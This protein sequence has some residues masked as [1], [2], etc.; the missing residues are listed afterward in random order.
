MILYGHLRHWQALDLCEER[1]KGEIDSLE[2]TSERRNARIVIG[3]DLDLRDR[4]L[5]DP[6]GRGHLLLIALQAQALPFEQLPLGLVHVYQ[7][8]SERNNT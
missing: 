1:R 3:V 4:A 2:C 7:Q 5:R 6:T 8:Y